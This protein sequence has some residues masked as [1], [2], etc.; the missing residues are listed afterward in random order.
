M[1]EEVLDVL[2]TILIKMARSEGTPHSEHDVN[3]IIPVERT[4]EKGKIILPFTFLL[5]CI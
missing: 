5:F 3:I 4:K 2:M 1:A